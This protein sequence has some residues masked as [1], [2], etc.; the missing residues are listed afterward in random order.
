MLKKTWPLLFLFSQMALADIPVEEAGDSNAS[1]SFRSA[2]TTINSS[3]LPAE[4]RINQTVE[5][6]VSQLEQQMANLTQ[7][8]LVSQIKQLQ[9]QVQTLQGQLDIQVHDLKALQD[10]QKLQ[11]QDIDQR[12]SGQKSKS[13]V[14]ANNETTTTPAVAVSPAT[15]STASMPESMHGTPMLQMSD[16]EAYQAA[17]NFVKAKDKSH[18]VAALQG[19]LKL[20][21]KGNFVGN[22]HYWLGEMLLAQDKNDAAIAEFNTLLQK[23]P[24]HANVADAKLKLGFAYYNK[25]QYS[26]AKTQLKLVQKEYP[27]SPVAQLATGRLEQM[28]LQGN[29]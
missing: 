8:N 1:A 19:Y 24:Q 11:F 25:G 6:R 23:F 28:K 16:Q 4:Q 21:P 12:L 26:L 17:Y 10:Q 15:N 22:A 14:M 13:V 29:K 7:M 9:Q 2:Q 5:Q 20:Y 27:D 3:N 18:A